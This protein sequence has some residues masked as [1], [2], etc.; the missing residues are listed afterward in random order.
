[1]RYRD[2][3]VSSTFFTVL[4]AI[5]DH[6]PTT[7]AETARRTGLRATQVRGQI[8]NHRYMYRNV[9][10]GFWRVARPEE[11]DWDD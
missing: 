5:Y 7:I 4:Y 10:H 9:S 11:M 8:I 3:H 6:Q 2:H 1:M